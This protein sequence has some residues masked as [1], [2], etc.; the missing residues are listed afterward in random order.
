MQKKLL[1]RYILFDRTEGALPYFYLLWLIFPISAL[2]NSQA[3]LSLCWLGWVL[4]GGFYLS[5]RKLYQHTGMMQTMLVIQMM[6]ALYFQFVYNVYGMI[7][8]SAFIIGSIPITKPQRRALFSIYYGALGL[9]FIGIGWQVSMQHTWFTNDDIPGLLLLSMFMV[10]APVV[11]NSARKSWEKGKYLEQNN[12]RLTDIVKRAEQNRIARELHDTLGQSFSMITVKTELASK[13]LAK[14]QTT[15]TQAQLAEIEQMSRENLQLVR[16]IV[17][18]LKQKNIAEVLVEQVANLEQVGI[19]CQTHTEAISSGW[20]REQQVLFGAIIQEAVTNIIRHS[21]ASKVD[22]YFTN[23]ENSFELKISDNGSKIVDNTTQSN[24]IKGM[25]ERV[26]QVAGHLTINSDK[27]ATTITCQ[28]PMEI[29]DDKIV[30][31]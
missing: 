1:T 25:Y 24:G 13:L 9:E 14:Q 11:A 12:A 10:A 2:L 26:N 4:L 21:E 18:A 15:A 27:Y 8:F 20:P 28:L 3:P 16:N 29:S 7:L 5:Y 30:L 19:K 31:S 22:M 17:R 6:I 23:L